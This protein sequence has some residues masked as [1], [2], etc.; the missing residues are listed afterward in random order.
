MNHNPILI[1]DID[2]TIYIHK[3]ELMDYDDVLPDDK[4]HNQLEDIN[5]PKFILTNATYDHANQILNHMNLHN[6][7]MKIYSRDNI[8]RMKPSL[9][10][11]QSVQQD[12]LKTIQNNHNNYIFF[13]DLLTNLRSA[14]TM[15]WKTVWI[16]PNYKLGSEYYFV[17]KA[18]PTLQDALDDLQF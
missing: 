2:D 16:S 5:C 10:C 12:I 14:Y 6:Q 1:I 4:L 11:Y 18:Y 13:D 8:P 3:S 17:N 7:F 9:A 15:G